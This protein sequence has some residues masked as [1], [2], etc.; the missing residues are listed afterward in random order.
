MLVAGVC[1]AAPAAGLSQSFNNQAV[2]SPPKSLRD[3]GIGHGQSIWSQP[4]QAVA[5]SSAAT[6]GVV[7]A[8]R[9]RDLTSSR[10]REGAPLAARLTVAARGADRSGR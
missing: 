2:L 7:A 3:V 6:W 8:C 5:G 10:Q 9:L 4:I 1:P